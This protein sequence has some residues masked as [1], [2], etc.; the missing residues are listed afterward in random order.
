MGDGIPGAAE[1]R[2]ID[3]DVRTSNGMPRHDVHLEVRLSDR[4]PYRATREIAL[5]L[6]SAPWFR[7]GAVLAVAA[8]RD[9]LQN[10]VITQNL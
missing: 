5:A 6:Q 8:D 3:E 7:P 1:I 4:D 10:V 9:D 2:A